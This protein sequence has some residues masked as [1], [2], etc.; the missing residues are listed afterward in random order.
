M[1]ILSLRTG[2]DPKG[3]QRAKPPARRRENRSGA[4]WLPGFFKDPE[5]QRWMILIGLSCVVAL[6][7]YPSGFSKP[8]D[9]KIGDVAERDIKAS[10]D[11]LVENEALTAKNRQGAEKEVLS[12]YDFD[13][14]GTNLV[15]RVNE[16]FRAG[17]EYVAAA[18]AAAEARRKAEAEGAG[19][20]EEAVAAEPEVEP[21]SE[22]SVREGFFEILDIPV[23]D[24]VFRTFL[25]AGF[26]EEAEK[27]VVELVQPVIEKG[28]V[29]NKSMLMSQSD[30]GILLHDIQTGKESEVKDLTT[31]YSLESARKTIQ[32]RRDELRKSM[33]PNVL[34][35]LCVE[36]AAV[37]VKPNLTFN[38]RETELRID[39]A[40]KSVKPFYYLVKK[41]EMLV[42]EGERVT[43]EHVRKL[44]EQNRRLHREGGLGR[45]PAI[46]LLFGL[47]L[48]AMYMTGL[49][50]R[51]VP[52]SET[53][54]VLFTALVILTMFLLLLAADIV[55]H[56][57]ARGFHFFSP[58]ALLYAA[59]VASGA[60]LVSVFMGMRV[61][62]S[63][64]V[65]AAILASLA[66][67]GQ[68]TF[69]IY[70]FVSALVGAHGVTH[71]RE[72]GVLIRCGLKVSL[73]N[74]VMACAIEAI[75][76]NFYAVETVIAA[77]AAFVGGI[78]AGV[79]TTGL[80][81][82]IEMCFGYTTDIKLLEL[83]NLDQPLLKELMVQAPGTYHH[84][85]IVSNMVEAAAPAV[86]ANPLLA[87]V[88]AYYHDIG[89]ARKPLYFI[90]NQIGCENRHE[91]LAPSMSGLILISHV[92]DGV[93][94]ARRYKLGKEITDIIMQHH[95]T[96]LIHFFF[97]KA[98]EQAEK[99]GLKGQQVKEEDF[100][101]PGPRPQTKEAGLVMLADIVEA[102]SK[103][104]VEPTGA[105]IQGLVQKMINKAFSDG[106]LDECELTLKDLHEI[107][108]SFN[109]TLSGIFHHRIEY[110]DAAAKSG[111]Q[112]LREKAG[113]G[114]EGA[115]RRM[116]PMERAAD[117][118][119]IVNG[120]T[121]AVPE[122]DQRSRRPE[123]QK[124][125]GESLK[126]LGL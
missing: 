8:A 113:P 80:L 55:S 1:K 47:L 9:Y 23:D 108:K 64:S 3:R 70:F 50:R 126:R 85:V 2:K 96:S 74:V 6:L 75:V 43:D 5:C 110:P 79:V 59:P 71:C 106:Q 116:A 89:K 69:F 125:T 30:K 105:R 46:A 83:S 65:I 7:I 86:G 39:E 84:S 24:T 31:F 21:L 36:L 15:Q 29:S 121:D 57:V 54:D 66:V 78:L 98:K 13:R 95:G 18:K 114:A 58:R 92:K 117:G 94:L 53:R 60:M 11:F 124:E 19:E 25:A 20:A 12:V 101:Y 14:S 97:E 40:R 122:A 93:E 34:A 88:A 120:H 68:A 63:F 112:R 76:G 45:I 115:E 49:M 102:A 26:P 41:G 51:R 33:L 61:A 82:L 107:A 100:R 109:K 22:A 35:N 103:T 38:K 62:A 28:V 72:R 17:R 27:W 123:D 87:K 73:V 81:P 56:E 52:T 37:I 104:L 4:G 118:K 32:S 42:R 111:P 119:R 91:R 10:R 48:A 16:S 67:E 90:E 99:K 44:A 77:T